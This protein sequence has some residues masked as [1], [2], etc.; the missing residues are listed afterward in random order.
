M[1]DPTLFAGRSDQIQQIARALQSRGSCPVIYGDRGLGKSSLA[2]QAVRIAL[3]D[4]TLLERYKLDQWSIS[5]RRAFVTF[6]VRCS[7]ATQTKDEVLQRVMNV[8]LDAFANEIWGEE[9]YQMTERSRTIGLNLKL[10]T[11][12]FGKK[13][14]PIQAQPD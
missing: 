14:G 1:D 11:A 9:T 6:Y 2:L 10:V 8:A 4:S 5:A 7:D 3:G 12:A 13:F